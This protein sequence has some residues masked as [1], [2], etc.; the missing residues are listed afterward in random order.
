M[1]DLLL[2][3]FIDTLKL[4]PF[5][6][7]TYLLM[8]LLEHKAGEK[9]KNIISRAGSFGPALG[10]LLGAVPQCGFSAAAAGLFSG[11]VVSAG[12]VIAIFLATSDEMIPVCISEKVGADVIAKI[13]IYKIL[14]GIIFGFA[15]D[16]I[17]KKIIKKDFSKNIHSICS[18]ENCHCE[19]SILKSSVH[20][21]I[22]ITLFILIINIA[23]NG[24]IFA[25][26]EDSLS[27][28]FVSIPVLTSFVSAIIGLIP[29]C[30]ASV[31]ITKLYLEGIISTGSLMA[32]LLAGS[33]LGILVL[34]KTNKSL[35][36]NILILSS[37]YAISVLCGILFDLFNITF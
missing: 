31:V 27:K 24:I 3:A 13:L 29:N 18:E 11:G 26:G 16:F 37:V 25:F 32:G 15:A 35:K 9:S 22:K 17:V 33:G 19:E 34:F 12:T 6:F 28:L 4:I 7:I 1:I 14:L 10:A 2:D 21:T 8:E 36:Q 5:L 20:H 23:V 30:A